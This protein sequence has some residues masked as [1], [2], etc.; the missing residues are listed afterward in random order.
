MVANDKLNI[1]NRLGEFIQ[2]QQS[3]HYAVAG[4][5]MSAIQQPTTESQFFFFFFF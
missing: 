3:T 1:Q 4:R 5:D 2:T